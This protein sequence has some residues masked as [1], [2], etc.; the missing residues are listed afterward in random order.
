MYGDSAV[1]TCQPRSR[2]LTYSSCFLQACLWSLLLFSA[3]SR[4]QRRSQGGERNAR[5]QVP[6]VL[7]WESSLW[8][9]G[10]KGS[11][12]S[13]AALGPVSPQG[14]LHPLEEAPSPT[15]TYPASGILCLWRP[16]GSAPR[17]SCTC[18]QSGCRAKDGDGN[19]S[20]SHSPQKQEQCACVFQDRSV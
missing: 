4:R 15:Q 6:L 9:Q 2:K 8:S 3:W 16:G 12:D 5:V 20:K 7:Q 14:H 17:C 10:L 11:D 19:Q 13:Q 1:L 18:P